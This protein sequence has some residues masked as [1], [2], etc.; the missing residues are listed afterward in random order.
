MRRESLLSAVKFRFRMSMLHYTSVSH[1][2][3]A[4]KGVV[5]K[6]VVEKCRYSIIC[7]N[8]AVTISNC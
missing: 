8:L 7:P 3:V 1:R 6:V 2:P 4:K 5:Y